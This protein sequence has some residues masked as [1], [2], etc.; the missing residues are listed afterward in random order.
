VSG[1][2]GEQEIRRNWVLEKSLFWSPDLL[3]LALSQILSAVSA[4]SAVFSSP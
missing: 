3:L 2:T 1:F 4:G